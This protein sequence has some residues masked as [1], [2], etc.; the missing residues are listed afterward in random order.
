MCFSAYVLMLGRCCRGWGV[1]KGV[2]KRNANPPHMEES[3]KVTTST[4]IAEPQKL[5]PKHPVSDPLRKYKMREDEVHTRP[6]HTITMPSCEPVQGGTRQEKMRPGLDLGSFLIGV[7]MSLRDSEPDMT[8]G[9]FG[10][11]SNGKHLL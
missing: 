6:R 5:S 3:S 2:T 8:Q 9:L 4:V 11:L 1:E 7:E 10:P